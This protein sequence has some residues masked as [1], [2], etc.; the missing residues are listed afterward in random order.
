MNT[1]EKKL[2]KIAGKT[3][4][5]T[6]YRWA[7]RNYRFVFFRKTM[8]KVI[9]DPQVML[10]DSRLLASLVYGWGNPSYASDTDFYTDC[11][12]YAAQSRLPILECGSGLT[13]IVAG[14]VAQKYG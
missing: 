4:L 14:L 8:R 3:P 6:I 12:K 7:R 1:A 13:T 5:G 9:A 10:H 2:R 11:A